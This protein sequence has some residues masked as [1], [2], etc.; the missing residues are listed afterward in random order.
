MD[1]SVIANNA[2]FFMKGFGVTLQLTALTLI[3][4]LIVGTP[5]ALGR[6]SHAR[7][8]RYLS[9][10]VI[11]SIRGTPILML[12]FWIY[13]LLPQVIGTSVS[14]YMA[15]LVALI[16][17][18]AAYSAEIIRAGIHS[19]DRGNIEAGRASGLTWLQISRHIV[20]PQAFS[21]M[22]PALISQAVMVY[23]TTSLIFVIG[24][25]DFFRAATIVNNREFKSFEIFTFVALV[26]F[27]PCTI[28]S[29]WSRGMEARRRLRLAT[30]HRV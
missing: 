11:E 24:V 25:V 10:V 22:K 2:S 7:L 1:F 8:A 27:I 29:R 18:N 28:I 6:A 9:I 17:F 14:A 15:G 3:G 23:K 30:V 16:T 4:G 5:L 12:I 20:L 13:F 21:N 26:Y 19:V